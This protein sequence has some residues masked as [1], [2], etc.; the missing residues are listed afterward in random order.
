MK[1]STVVKLGGSLLENARLRSHALDAVAEA[2]SNGQAL[3]VMHGGG[4]KIDALS[5]KLGLR[6]HTYHGLRIT[7]AETLEVVVSVLAGVVNKTLVAELHRKGVAA[8]GLSG[9]DGETLVAELHPRINSI[10][11]GFVGRIVEAHTTLIEGIAGSGFLPV[12][13][14]IASG[15]DGTLLNVNADSAASALAV[16]LQSR[17][18]VF[19]TDVEGLLDASG[20][21]VD[22]LTVER[23]ESFLQS[24]SVTGG[25]RPKLRAAI[26]ALAGGVE[27]V[28]IA[29]PDRHRHALLQGEGGTHLVAA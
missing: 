10:D 6:K 17:R 23:A 26:D 9:V 18:L 1:G 13:G 16:A 27:E 5:S 25:M 11:Y 2:W 29:G 24:G 7:N 8:V 4:K 21:I 20:Q 3:A 14:S 22:L 28:I 19:L 15:P 12:I